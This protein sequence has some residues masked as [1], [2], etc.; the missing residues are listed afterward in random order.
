[1][2]GTVQNSASVKCG[3][4]APRCVHLKVSSSSQYWVGLAHGVL[5]SACIGSDEGLV[6]C[7]AECFLY[8]L[9][10]RSARMKVAGLCVCSQ[11]LV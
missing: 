6:L 2:P 4:D 7:G 9:M 11:D 3:S 1:M 5:V 10:Q 8:R